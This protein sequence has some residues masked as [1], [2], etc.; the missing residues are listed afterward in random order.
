MAYERIESRFLF[1]HRHRPLT[2]KGEGEFC[3]KT[4]PQE[5]D[6]TAGRPCTRARRATTRVDC[7]QS[8][9]TKSDRTAQ[10]LQAKDSCSSAGFLTSTFLLF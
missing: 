1:L 8:E 4:V 2:V 10:Y 9:G 7:K 3:K 6:T 5:T